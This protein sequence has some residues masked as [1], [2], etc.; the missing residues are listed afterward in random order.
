[1]PSFSLIEDEK[2]SIRR[3]SRT[4]DQFS[5]KDSGVWSVCWRGAGR[6]SG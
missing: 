4:G 1:M 2:P 5:L 3:K 6:Y